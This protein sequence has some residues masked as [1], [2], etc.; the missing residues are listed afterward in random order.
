MSA[1]DLSSKENKRPLT[2]RCS[3]FHSWTRIHENVIDS[4]IVGN[5][6][7]ERKLAGSRMS[8]TV[9][10]TARRQGGGTP[11]NLRELICA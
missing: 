1:F 9:G 7:L 4:L 10:Q 2:P 6:I 8:M 3:S 5:G 11:C